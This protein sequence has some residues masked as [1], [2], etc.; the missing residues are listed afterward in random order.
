MFKTEIPAQRVNYH[1]VSIYLAVGRIARD[2]GRANEYTL[3]QLRVQLWLTLPDIYHGIAHSS[4][5]KGR[6]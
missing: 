5:T 1:V 3:Q 6:E 2:V 4:V